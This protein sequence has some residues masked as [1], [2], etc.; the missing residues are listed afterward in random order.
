MLD[1]WSLSALASRSRQTVVVATVA[2]AVLTSSLRPAG[3]AEQTL[4]APPFPVRPSIAAT[5]IAPDEAPAIDGDLSDP[6]WAK[7][8]SLDSFWQATP[9]PGDAANERTLV[10]VL[11]DENNLYFGIYAYDSAPDLI[12]VRA[13]A[14]DGDIG[15]G[16][17]VR[18][19]L[20][21]GMTRR[22]GYTFQ[23]GPSGGRIDAL[24]QNNTDNLEQWNAIWTA[25]A[26]VV[27]D[28]WIVEVAIPFRSLSYE[29]GQTDWGLELTRQIRHRN[30]TVR[31]SNYNPAVNFTD[32]TGTGTLTGITGI[33]EG[34]GLDLQLYG[35]ARAKRDW[36]IPGED[37]G[38][39]FTGGGNAF[40]KLTPALT[41]TLTVNPDFSD[42]PLDARQINTTRFSLFTPETRDFFLQ[43]AAAF[44]F[45][46]RNFI[47]ANNGR[48]F[49]SRNIGL[50]RGVPISL[51]GGGKLSGEYAGFDIGA[52]SVV[53][54]RPPGADRQVL[55]VARVTRPVLAESKLGFIVT[56]GDP[57]GATDNT[58]AGADFQYRNSN[59]AGNIVQS[60]LYYERSF[61]SRF[62]D[63]D[64]F[65]AGLNFP[66]EPWAGQLVVK[67]IGTNFR[68][69]LGFVNRS[70]IWSYAASGDYRRRF[71]NAALREA[72]LQADNTFITGLNGHLESRESEFNLH[73]QTPRNEQF[74]LGLKSYF[75]SVPAPFALPGNVIVP[76]GDYSWNNAHARFVSSQMY[77]F[78]VELEGSCCSFYNGSGVELQAELN[79]RP[80][81]YFELQPGYEGTYIDLPTGSVNIHLLTVDVILNFTPDMQVA[82]QTQYDNISES[83][84]LLARY[85]WEFRPGS[86]LFVAF[87]QAAVIP[88]TTFKPQRSQLQ[89]R[90]GH[91]FRF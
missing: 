42:A 10:R 24:L 79:Y 40:Y 39:S 47:N 78:Q 74:D 21:P 66:N 51:V 45:G 70:G 37:T 7:A 25:R 83:F 86:E 14:R 36:H 91:T 11:Y 59:V 13:M 48:P 76:A 2:L 72:V 46:G 19:V 28:G 61:S 18:I 30:E 67:R 22:N 65:G 89:I 75:E 90:L 54:D 43:D 38:L 27:S 62:G 50:A 60:D 73:G 6:V 69:A 9:N 12:S 57:T 8:R 77:P 88:G 55:S 56:N 1:L 81:Q 68:P 20:D 5:R 58:V 87:G 17:T 49:F 85:R 41:G 44:E 4:R 63:D 26:R 34:L 35:V 31:W 82:L 23:L 33:R 84:G 16:D 32:L 64:S 52:L 15:T 29:P 53:T 80:N 3:A 71:R